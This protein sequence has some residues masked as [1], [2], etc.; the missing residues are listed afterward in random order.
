MTRE[1]A[2]VLL[3]DGTVASIRPISAEDGPALTDLHDSIGP[4]NV[5]LRFFSS[6]RVAGRQYVAHVLDSPDT[7]AL[8]AERRGEVVALGTAEPV[9]AGTA[10]IAFLVADECHGLGIGSLLLEHL[11]AAGREHG[12]RRFTAEVLSENAVMLD[13]LRHAGFDVTHRTE[14]GCV[15]VEM[16]TTAS[17]DAL[18]AADEREALTEA[19]S[20]APLL[21]P[22]SVAVVGARRSGSGVGAAVLRSIVSGGYTGTVHV[23]HP[24]AGSMRGVPAVRSLAELPVPADLVVVAVPAP[25]V[26]DVLR[27]AAAAQCRGAVVIS[28]GFAEAGP[29]GAALQQ[30]VLEIARASSM[31]V[32]GPNCLGILNTH[33]AVRLDATFSGCVPPAGGLTLASQS[34]G[35][36]IVLA[37]LARQLGLGVGMLVSLGNKVDVSG[38]D[39]LAAW[40]D[41]PH[42]TAAALYLESFGNAPKFARVAR[43]FSERKPLLAVVGGRSAGGRRG[44][45]S[46]TAAEASPLV[47]VRALFAQAGVIACGSAE[48]LADCA[49]LLGKQPRPPGRRVAVL[50]NAGGM[51]VL[52]ADTAEGAG[53]SVPELSADLRGRLASEV[54]GTVATGNP[55]DAGPA[56]GPRTLA[57]LADLLLGS[58]EVDVLLVVLVAT[59]LGNVS[60][61]AQA[62]PEVR[63]RY[64]DKPVLLVPLGGL[65]IAP[66]ALDGVTAYRTADAAVRALERA[67]WYDEW[68]RQPPREEAPGDP[69]RAFRARAAAHDLVAA[70]SGEGWLDALASRALLAEYGL[71]PEGRFAVGRDAAV[72]AAKELG[73]PVVVKAAG[74]AVVHRTEHGLVRVGLMT[75]AEVVRAVQAFEAEVGEPAEVLVQPVLSGTEI[76]LGVVRD[77]RFGP[78]VMVGAGGVAT[79]LWDDRAYLLPP[80]SPRDAARAVR[81]LR[82]WPLLQGFRG[83]PAGDVE[84]LEDLLVR[85]G[86]LA[87]DVPAVAEVDAH[88]A[89]ERTMGITTAGC[90]ISSGTMLIAPAGHSEAQTPQPLQ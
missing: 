6:S 61:A 35:V 16:D 34:G 80:V 83:A 18:R 11:A 74:D 54:P 84:G 48:E 77:P 33:P 55:V 71:G 10:E 62:L 51:G 86:R 68:R 39:L 45:S 52:A 30:E 3:T 8:V 27:D 81:S 17:Y 50:T 24:S 49:L 15:L 60:G 7:L 46:H 12:V 2:D 43:E 37:D 26:V 82:V 75:R 38:N 32:V 53:L 19:R 70:G 21:R 36:G 1:R 56:A 85:L 42:V 4:E 63:R 41:D 40:R 87:D 66:S 72:A 9:G 59:G 88:R 22:R 78:L 20:L 65:D 73:Y 28:A 47:G 29:E 64:P 14:A 58:D 67:A 13:I 90:Q 76:A 5:R 23:V 25:Q 69:D 57:M 31:R 79:E 89:R 44:G